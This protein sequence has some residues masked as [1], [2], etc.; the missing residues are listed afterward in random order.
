MSD[1]ILAG[2]KL[3]PIICTLQE[4]YAILGPITLGYTWGQST[5]K[6]LWSRCAPTPDSIYG[7][8]TERRIISPAHLG[9]WLADVLNRQ[10][11]PLDEAASVYNQFMT[12]GKG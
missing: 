7:T 12:R 6:D 4:A 3:Y 10:G 5:I 11:K 8:A 1:N 2:R 9:E